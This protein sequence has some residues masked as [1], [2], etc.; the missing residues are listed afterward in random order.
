MAWAATTSSGR[1][2]RARTVTARCASPACAEDLAAAIE[3]LI[4]TGAYGI[5]HFTNDGACSRYEF[6]QK[7]LE[8]SGR[9]HIPIEPISLKDFGRPSTPP[10]YAPLR[11]FCRS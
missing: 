11:T 10:P 5:Y 7:I 2:S 3:Q 4:D 6:A 1:S 9:G 8:L